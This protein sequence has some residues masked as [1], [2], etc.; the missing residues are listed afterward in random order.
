MTGRCDC[1]PSNNVVVVAVVAKKAEEEEGKGAYTIKGIRIV[2][3]GDC[4][5]CAEQYW[6]I[7]R[8]NTSLSLIR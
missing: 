6:I 3:V 1:G 8:G 7:T 5:P 4:V 2:I